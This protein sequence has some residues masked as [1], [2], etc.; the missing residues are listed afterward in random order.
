MI[1]SAKAMNGNRDVRPLSATWEVTTIR[2]FVSSLVAVAAPAIL[3]LLVLLPPLLF[4]DMGGSDGWMF[5]ALVMA[6]AT[7][8][9]AFHFVVFGIPYVLVLLKMG[10]LG[11]LSIVS[12][13]F[14]IGFLPT[15]VFSELPKLLEYRISY[16]FWDI[17]GMLPGYLERSLEPGLFGALSG[18]A[19]ML[20]FRGLSAADERAARR[21]RRAKAV[22]A[23][24][25]PVAVYF[26]SACP[27]CRTGVEWQQGQASSCEIE[28]IDVH[29]MPEAIADVGAGLEDVRERLHVRDAEG[30]VLVGADAVAFVM[31]T[32]PGQRV[33][34]RLS[35]L[36][37]VRPLMRWG[38]NEFAR[39]LYRWNRDK[40]R[41]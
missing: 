38:Y 27:V 17:V 18:L 7:L 13:G 36:P 26:N 5:A 19:F 4:S 10:R 6:V 39:I 3:L 12:G 33:L 1:T 21:D 9:S 34:G 28:W 40:G 11:W 25:H 37:W 41:W 24:G 22:A 32:R 30:R 2:V 31:G 29:A 20:A 16:G 15:F 23:T 14:A 8:F 35:A